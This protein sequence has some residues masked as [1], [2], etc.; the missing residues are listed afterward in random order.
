MDKKVIK[1]LILSAR[2]STVYSRSESLMFKLPANP[3]LL[4]LECVIEKTAETI[5]LANA[6]QARALELCPARVAEDIQ[7]S[8]DIG[9]VGNGIRGEAST[10]G[11][12]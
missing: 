12:S 6:G 5:G 10:G 9:F 7:I 1:C 11:F 3:I 8:C 4:L 2:S